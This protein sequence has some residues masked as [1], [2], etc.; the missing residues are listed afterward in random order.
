[1][2]A[3]ETT[4]YIRG[5]LFV[6]VDFLLGNSFTELEVLAEVENF[7]KSVLRLIVV[8]LKKLPTLQST[9]EE[10]EKVPNLFLVDPLAAIVKSCPEL[11]ETLS[12]LFGCCLRAL[13]FFSFYDVNQETPLFITKQV[14]DSCV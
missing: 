1:M 10:L 13:K 6:Y 14:K 11:M 8:W 5:E 3:F 9:F 7:I 4:Q 2:T 12:K